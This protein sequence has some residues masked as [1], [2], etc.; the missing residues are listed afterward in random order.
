MHALLTHRRFIGREASWSFSR[1]VL[2]TPPPPEVSMGADEE[3]DVRG[4]R[5]LDGGE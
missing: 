2:P 5:G 1:P 3:D 4:S